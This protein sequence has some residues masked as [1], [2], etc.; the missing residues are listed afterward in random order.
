MT[1]LRRQRE[2][3]GY[4][5]HAGLEHLSGVPRR[6]LVPLGV[7]HHARAPGGQFSTGSPSA[8]RPNGPDVLKEEMSLEFW[9]E[10]A[11]RSSD[12][13]DDKTRGHHFPLRSWILR[14]ATDLNL[15]LNQGQA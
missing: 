13:D 7:P 14:F 10:L 12:L 4:Q 3:R 15:Q 2:V 6:T 9:A 1:A 5:L 11:E 8:S